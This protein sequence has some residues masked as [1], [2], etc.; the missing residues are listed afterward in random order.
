MADMPPVAPASNV[1]TA[2]M[3]A[4]SR[5]APVKPSAEPGLKPNQPKKR[6]IVPRMPIGMLWPGMALAVPFL[7]KRPMRGPMTMAP[8]SAVTP[9][10][11]CTTPEPAKSTAPLPQPMVRPRLASQPPPHTHMPTSG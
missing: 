3:T 6:M 11:M 1:L 8:A 2:A 9:P 10:I 5:K 7:L 4:R